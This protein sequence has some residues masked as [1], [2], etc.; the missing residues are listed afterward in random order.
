MSVYLFHMNYIGYFCTREFLSKHADSLNNRVFVFVREFKA[1][2]NNAR[3]CHVRYFT[4]G[5]ES[6][7]SKW[8]FYDSF[9]GAPN[10]F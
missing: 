2:T 4:D 10:V 7:C 6:V 8:L 1:A 3:N 9:G 5:S